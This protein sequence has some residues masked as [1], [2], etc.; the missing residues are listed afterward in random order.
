MKIEKF[1]FPPIYSEKRFEIM[2]NSD[3]I[4]TSYYECNS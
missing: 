2:R 1:I 4:N 3:L